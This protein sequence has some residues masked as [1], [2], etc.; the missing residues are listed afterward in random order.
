[1]LHHESV[2]A[3]NGPAVLYTQGWES[4]KD[5]GLPNSRVSW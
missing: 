4:N 5:P 3:Q 1:M 2:P